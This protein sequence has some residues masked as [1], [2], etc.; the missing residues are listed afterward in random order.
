MSGSFLVLLVEPEPE[1]RAVLKSAFENE[2][3]HVLAPD[4]AG[5]LTG[6]LLV[7][8]RLIVV[9]LL[10][11]SGPGL[12]F[13]RARNESPERGPADV[14][15]LHDAQDFDS[16]DAALRAGADDT[17][18]WPTT[19]ALLRTRLRLLSNVS[20]LRAEAAEV[21]RLLVRLVDVHEQRDEPAPGH[22]ERVASLALALAAQAGMTAS[23]ADRIGRAG[24]IHD[25]GF[26]AISDRLFLKTE[27]LSRE[28][29]AQLRSH[30]VI[31][32]ELLRG[33]SS[34]EPLR[35]L[36][37]RHHERL[38]GSGYPDGLRGREI[39]VSVQ[40]LSLAD[41]YDGMTSRRPYRAAFATLT[42][43]DTLWSEARSGL[44]DP[45]LVDLLG[46]T[47]DPMVPV[48]TDRS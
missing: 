20:L 22:S 12:E 40:I 44:W 5:A 26:L 15:A 43:L 17:L 42:A 10:G 3:T 7:T 39:P 28:E 30:P 16:A 6:S 4:M 1:R 31:G 14:L 35:P 23:D 13:L 19:S 29:T 47:L 45:E 33:V 18:S 38:D 36:V 21:S 24:Q 8:P 46:K 11:D 25:I 48:R 9:S 32:S 27:P 37:H 41:A 34:L 2:Q